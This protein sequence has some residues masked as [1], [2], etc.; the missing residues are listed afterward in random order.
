M[1]RK[2]RQGIVL[3]TTLLFVTI[4]VMIAT[5]IAAQG[6]AALQSGTASMQAEEAYMAAL[7][8]IDVVRGELKKSKT[9]GMSSFSGYDKRVAEKFVDGLKIQYMDKDLVGYIGANDSDQDNYKSKFT[10]SFKDMADSTT[11]P[12][13]TSNYKHVTSDCKYLSVN[14]MS[15]SS[16][17]EQNTLKGIR[18]KVPG[19]TCYIVS[20]GVCGKAVR[21]AEAFL[22]SNG[23]AVID[24]GSTIGGNINIRGFDGKGIIKDDNGNYKDYDGTAGNSLLTVKHVDN[25]YAGQLNAFN[26]SDKNKCTGNI[27]LY[28]EDKSKGD[29]QKLL[30]L[31]NKIN[32]N[33]KFN[34]DTDKVSNLTTD[35]DLT[36]N[37]GELDKLTFAEAKKTVKSKS[38]EPIKLD[39]GTYIYLRT[40]SDDSSIG[41]D[42][43]WVYVNN[44]NIERAIESLKDKNGYTNVSSSQGI[45]FGD[46]E[47]ISGYVSR[48][49]KVSDNVTSTGNVNFVVVDKTLAKNGKTVYAQSGATVDFELV[50]GGAI[51]SDGDINIQGEVTGSGNL[52]SN[53]NVMFRAGSSL[54]VD[55]NQKVAVWAGGEVSIDRAKD[56]S[57]KALFRL[58]APNSKITNNRNKLGQNR[59]TLNSVDELKSALSG[60]ISTLITTNVT[61]ENYTSV[62]TYVAE[63]GTVVTEG[64]E[65]V[66]D[67]TQPTPEP[68]PSPS[69]TQTPPLPPNGPE[70]ITLNDAQKECLKNLGFGEGYDAVYSVEYDDNTYY[71]AKEPGFNKILPLET[72]KA[73][74]NNVYFKLTTGGNINQC[75]TYALDTTQ[76]KVNLTL[77]DNSEFCIA[78]R[79]PEGTYDTDESKR[80]SSDFNIFIKGEDNNY[81]YY[82]TV[83]FQEGAS[84]IVYEAESKDEIGARNSVGVDFVVGEDGEPT[85]ITGYLATLS[86]GENTQVGTPEPT[87]KNALP[88]I[89]ATKSTESVKQ[90]YDK[91]KNYNTSLRG[92]IYSKK[93]IKINVGDSSFEILGALIAMDGGL[94]ITGKHVDL[95]YDPNYVPFFNDVGINTN[96]EFLSS[97]VGGE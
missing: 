3:I 19:Y 12:T 77:G 58:Y 27:N 44:D 14:N 70:K 32:I 49:V 80:N 15:S 86:S 57:D 5:M 11:N 42:T 90:V 23:S 22:T 66:I 78:P 94:D 39:S 89:V 38:T 84:K 21:Y 48:K 54:E 40:Q 41:Y 35:Q 7:S 69:P 9:F 96:V 1:K 61:K 46:S 52:I 53:N 25:K 24:N 63:D 43:Q 92:T 74:D 10:I 36:V 81:Y 6:K 87:E 85:N 76:R 31:S 68:S 67:T 93:G 2:K 71:F 28:S 60:G 95:T 4:I 59:I 51:T 88:T 64:I 16:A 13:D 26:P 91:V 83:D 56:I 37:K 29:L 73:S 72:Y 47:Q 34:Y 33:G 30:N 55:E 62:T 50:D 45:S 65:P 20:K 75:T 82:K 97:F 79:W 8:G 17:V 18:R